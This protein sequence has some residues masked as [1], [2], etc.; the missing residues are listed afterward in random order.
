LAWDLK[1]DETAFSLSNVVELAI[2]NVQK[3]DHL[4]GDDRPDLFSDNG[5]GFTAKIM[6]EY[7][8]EHGIKH[9]FGKPYHPQTQGKIGRFHR[10][11]KERICLLIY[12]SPDELKKALDSAIIKYAMTPAQSFIKR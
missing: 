1:P 6:A 10:S 11:I 4:S 5:S 2:E 3:Q 8:D 12:C 9:I 7:M